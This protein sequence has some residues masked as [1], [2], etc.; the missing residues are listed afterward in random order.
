VAADLLQDDLLDLVGGCDAVVHIATA[1]PADS[2][3][4]GAWDL[5]ARLR[6][7]GTRRL[8]G[9][10][11]ACHVTRY[12]QQSIVMAYRDGGDTWLDEG[13]PLDDSTRRA[14]ICGPVIEMETIIRA[15]EPQDL[16]WTILRGGSFVGPG[17]A[18]NALIDTLRSGD[19]VIAGDGSNYISPVNVMDMASA[20]RGIT[21][22]R[23][24]RFDVQHCRRANSVRRLR[25]RT[26][27][28]DRHRTPAT[29]T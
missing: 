2:S 25:R 8:M 21:R 28:L 5:N 29:S 19:V 20:V 24:C 22:A 11:L 12:V 13:A 17:T 4:P 15:V 9:A 16:A 1:I 26:C 3:V 18:Q 10:A 14:A 6:T 27:R 7:V 23:T